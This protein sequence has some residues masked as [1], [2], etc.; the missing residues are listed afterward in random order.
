VGLGSR[1]KFFVR[2]AALKY[3][4]LE[5]LPFLQKA[6][7]NTTGDPKCSPMTRDIKKREKKEKKEKS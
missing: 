1:Q 4:A 7:F 6:V 3:K 2:Q 5:L